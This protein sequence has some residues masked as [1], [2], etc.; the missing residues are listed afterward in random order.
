MSTATLLLIAKAATNLRRF[1]VL[2]ENV[3]CA[4][5][6]PPNPDWTS[7]F[8]EWLSLASATIPSTEREIARILGCSGWQLLDLDA[9]QKVDVDVRQS[10]G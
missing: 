7:E 3:R 9:Y 8:Y 6:W 1:Y 10:F 2:R 4:G 5:D